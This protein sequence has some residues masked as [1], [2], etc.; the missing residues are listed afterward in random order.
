MERDILW[1]AAHGM[2]YREMAARRY[3]HPQIV[4][5]EASA[6]L[7]KLGA[8]SMTQAVYI[9]VMDGLIGRYQACGSLSMYEVHR[10]RHE[11]QDPRCLVV[12]SD[13]DRVKRAARK[14]ENRKKES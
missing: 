12:K 7:A 3:C 2:T 4:K 9:A 8:R 6:L 11:P 10:R 14:S 13:H 1:Q 5:T